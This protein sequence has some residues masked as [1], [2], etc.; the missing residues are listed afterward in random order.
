MSWIFDIHASLSVRSE[1]EL[2]AIVVA[3]AA[4]SLHWSSTLRCSNVEARRPHTA[5][6]VTPT[7][8]GPLKSI[9]TLAILA[10]HRDHEEVRPRKEG[11]NHII[12]G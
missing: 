4:L 9:K 10:R 3:R 1:L 2:P 11:G 6:N 5:T 8:N 12:T 7:R